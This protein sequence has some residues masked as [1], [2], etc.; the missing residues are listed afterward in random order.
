[1]EKFIPKDKLSKKKKRELN[2]E[3]RVMWQF[4]P[5]SRVIKS[6]KVYDRKKRDRNMYDPASFLFANVVLA[7]K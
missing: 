6:K 7:E 3:K 2:S 1:M 4:S 5:D